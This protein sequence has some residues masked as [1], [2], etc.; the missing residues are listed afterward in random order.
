MAART[1]TYVDS[2]DGIAPEHLAGF[3]AGWPNPPSRDVHFEILRRSS[4]VTLAVD[5]DPRRVVGF[6]TAITDGILSAYIPLLEVLP[7]YRGIGIGRALVARLLDRLRHLY[8]V[9]LL[10]DPELQPF[11]EKLGMRRAHG[12]MLRNY[13][14]QSGTDLDAGRDG[15]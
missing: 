1:I 9:D 12:M 4:A 8:M 7:E 14:R 2:L 10:C 3:F 6:I 13:A 15:M 5:R 11:Y